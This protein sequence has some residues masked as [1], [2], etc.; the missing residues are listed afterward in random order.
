MGIPGADRLRKELEELRRELHHHLPKVIQE[1]RSHGDLSENAEYEAAKERQAFVA[2]RIA[3]LEE[4][5]R[6]LSMINLDTVPRGRVAYGS[7]VEIENLRTGEVRRFE[8]VTSAEVDAAAGRISAES[9]LGRALLNR[10]VGDE[11]Q[12]QTPKGLESY[13]IIGLTTLHER[14]S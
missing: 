13:E 5:L 11:I 12:V 8:L 10:E 2:A 7:V 4:Q 14:Q 1:A 6:E 3:Q 9:P